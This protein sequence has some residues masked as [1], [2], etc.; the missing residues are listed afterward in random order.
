MTRAVL[1]LL[2]ILF[3]ILGQTSTPVQVTI[4]VH[5]GPSGGVTI[6]SSFLGLGFETG[7]LTSSS[8]FPAED[9]VFR[10]MISQLGP[11]WL[12]FGGNSVDRLGWIRGQRT[13]STPNA[14]LTSSDVDR[15]LAFARAVGWRVLWGLNL[16]TATTAT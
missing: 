3:P 7:S 6:P 1:L 13:S 10:Q 5:P 12:R 11:G 2:L 8:G 9:P 15:V 14:V 4:A 16:A